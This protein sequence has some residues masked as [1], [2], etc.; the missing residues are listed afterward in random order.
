MDSRSASVWKLCLMVIAVL[1]AAVTVSAQTPAA[2]TA[3]L[4]YLNSHQNANGTWGTT[5]ELSARDTARVLIVE[6]LLR[7]DNGNTVAGTAWL[8]SQGLDANQFLAE[9]AM[10]LA[11]QNVNAAP[12]LA[13][14]AQ[15]RSSNAPDF[16]GFIDHNGDT[17]DSALAVQALASQE[18]AWSTTISG[19]VSTL[20]GR[21]NPDGGWGIDQGFDSNPVLTS[22]VLVA[23]TSLKNLQAAPAVIAAAQGYLS[24]LIHADGSIGSGPLETAS[25]FRALALSGYPLSSTSA[26]TFTYLNGQQGSNGSWGGGSAYITARVLEAY[27]ANKPNLVIK[28]ADFSLNPRSTTEGSNVT[29]V[30][31][32]NPLNGSRICFT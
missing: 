15:Q 21:Q 12:A 2:V 32:S 24:R 17:L 3:G 30:S 8:S 22:E 28:S 13:K 20:I 23:L 14:L 19:A 29:Q 31:G 25:A 7:T 27:A 4:T 1:L 9:Q 6:K 10:A 26:A 16:G 11:L 18:Q 5:P